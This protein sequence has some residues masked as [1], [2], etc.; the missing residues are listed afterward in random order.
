VPA[1]FCAPHSDFNLDPRAEPIND[2]HKAIDGEPFE[3]CIADAREVGGGNS[4]AAVRR[5][6]AQSLPVERLD[7][8]GR[9]NRLE[10]LS[11]CVLVSQVGNTFPLPRTT[12][13]FSLFIATYP[14]RPVL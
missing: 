10:L 13:S 4:R 8:F 2:G 12:F 1:C 7:D 3:V 5:A 11:V 14:F 6:H 9:Q